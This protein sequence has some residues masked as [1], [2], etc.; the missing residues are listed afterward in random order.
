MSLEPLTEEFT[1]A[2]KKGMGRALQH[3]VHHGIGDY[4]DLV[5]DACLHNQNYDPQ[6][7]SCRAPW[8]LS[9]FRNTPYYEEFRKAIMNNLE[10]S[11]SW[12]LIQLC[13][14]LREMAETGDAL[15]RL[16]LKEIAFTYAISGTEDEH[17][18][19][20][21]F[22]DLQTNDEFLE[23]ARIFGNR[24]LEDQEAFPFDQL[25]PVDGSF[26]EEKEQEFKELLYQFAQRDLS[27]RKYWQYLYERGDLEDT[28]IDD[29]PEIFDEDAF[30]RDCI[31]KSDN[32]STWIKS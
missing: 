20:D 21:E 29:T 16:K 3:I 9:M 24:L 26:S 32:Y 27:I 19:V 17:I 23:L 15:A 6:I 13:D 11:S 18:I 8:L 7:D 22:T 10:T 31:T 25:I 14:F 12:D 5:L 2:L 28:P 30:K 4:K 1:A